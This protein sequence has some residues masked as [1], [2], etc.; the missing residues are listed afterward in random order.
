MDFKNGSGQ[1]GKGEPNA[2]ADVTI[3]MN[4]ANF[5]KIFNREYRVESRNCSEQ[6]RN[7]VFALVRRGT[8]ASNSIYDR[9]DKSER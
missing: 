5:L 1:V 3:S 9:P 6:R 2:K 8:I 4:T 7:R